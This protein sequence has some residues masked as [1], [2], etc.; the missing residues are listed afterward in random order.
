MQPPAARGLRC[1]SGSCWRRSACTCSPAPTC[2]SGAASCSRSRARCCSRATSCTSARTRTVLPPAAFTAHAARRWWRC[3][4]VPP[5]GRAGRRHRS[6][7]SRCSRS[8]SP[9][10]ACSA[11]AL[12]L[13]LWG[14]RRIPATRAALILLSEPVFA[15]IA[16]YV[17]GERLGASSSSARSSIL[18]GI[19]VSELWPRRPV[20]PAEV[21]GRHEQSVDERDA[22]QVGIVEWARAHRERARRSRCGS[23]TTLGRLGRRGATRRRQARPRSPRPSLRVARRAVGRRRAGAPRLARRA[24]A[25]VDESLARRRGRRWPPSP[26]REAVYDDVLPI[27]GGGLPHVVGESTPDRRPADHARARPRAPRPRL[28]RPG[29]PRPVRSHSD[30]LSAR[31]LGAA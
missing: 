7:R 8:C 20:P 23:P 5:A 30:Q 14:Q 27:V 17:N 26:S 10:I 31:P 12:P 25:V 15:G 1:A 11:V 13:Q 22:T 6:P 3:S 18:V 4:A 19:A 16:G 9:G 28:R 21:R 29:G 2:T 24:S